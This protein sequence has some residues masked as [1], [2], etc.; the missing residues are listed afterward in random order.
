MG[1]ALRELGSTQEALENLKKAREV[2]F[3]VLA[4][5]EDIERTDQEINMAENY[6]LRG[7]VSTEPPC[8][9]LNEMHLETQCHVLSH[10]NVAC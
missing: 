10:H 1:C 7:S 6:S 3:R 8:R 4:S 2:Q 9:M 5:K